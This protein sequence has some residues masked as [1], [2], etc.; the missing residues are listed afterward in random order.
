[1]GGGGVPGCTWCCVPWGFLPA[2]LALVWREGGGRAGGV[3]LDTRLLR[4]STPL[5]SSAPSRG[6]EKEVARSQR[7]PLARS[8]SSVASPRS[9]PHARRREKLREVSEDCSRVRSSRGYRSSDRGAREDRR[10]RS[11]SRGRSSSRSLS[12]RVRSRSSNRS[13]SRHVRSRSRGDRSRSSD[14]YLS[15]RDRLRPS[16]RYRSHRQRARSPAR[17][18]ARGHAISS[19]V[20]V[21]ARVLADDYLPPL[22]VRRQGR[23]D[24]EPDE[25][26]RRV[27][28]R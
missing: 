15:R 24:G 22:T 13:R 16:D 5:V 1:M 4:A 27:W 7:T 10:A 14:R 28:R 3:S 18:G 25:S 11:R 23:K 20:L 21:T 26:S 8:A 6:A 12:R 19:V 17:R 9:S 2:R